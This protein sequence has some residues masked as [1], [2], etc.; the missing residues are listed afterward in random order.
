MYCVPIQYR[1]ED[2]QTGIPVLLHTAVHIHL[3]IAGYYFQ[4]T[5]LLSI[6]SG[7]SAISQLPFRAVS[8]LPQLAWAEEIVFSNTA[9]EFS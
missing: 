1:T 4:A 9:I 2:L 8:I 3:Y 6:F 5:I 7:Q